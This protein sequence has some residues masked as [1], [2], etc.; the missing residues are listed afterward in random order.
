MGGARGGLEGIFADNGSRLGDTMR[1]TVLSNVKDAYAIYVVGDSM[2]P[3][4]YGG[5]L[6][7]IN[8]QKPI[9]RGSFVVVQYDNKG[10]RNYIIKQFIKK[11]SEY[12]VLL[13][14]NPEKEMEIG[15]NLVYS[16]HRVVG[17]IDG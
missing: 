13:Q 3:R 1:P 15:I 11:T 17:S 8:P 10:E 4:Y 5:E 16:V 7:F 12:I 6:A 9:N 2:E 14:L